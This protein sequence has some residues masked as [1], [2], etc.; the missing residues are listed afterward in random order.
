VESL[1]VIFS[2]QIFYVF[3]VFAI[4]FFVIWLYPLPYFGA[5][6]DSL[7]ITHCTIISKYGGALQK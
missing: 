1:F 3:I 4:N 5:W 2:F 6:I 7:G